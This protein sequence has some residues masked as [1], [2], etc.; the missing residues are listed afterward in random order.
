M[1]VCVLLSVLIKIQLS[2]EVL[3]NSPES[4]ECNRLKIFSATI[5]MNIRAF[6][7]VI[8]ILSLYCN[9]VRWH[10]NSWHRAIENP[11]FLD[12]KPWNSSLSRATTNIASLNITVYFTID[13]NR[14]RCLANIAGLGNRG[15]ILK[16]FYSISLDIF[17]R[18][19]SPWNQK[20]CYWSCKQ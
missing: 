4:I 12:V 11:G 1:R 13:F 17:Y 3:R 20:K 18:R 19:G 6:E 14:K 7:I 10:D 5:S 15:H 8:W 2:I 16:D 9:Q